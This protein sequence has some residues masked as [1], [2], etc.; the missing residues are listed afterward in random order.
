MKKIFFV[1]IF[2]LCANFSCKEQARDNA[3]VRHF[4]ENKALFERTAAYLNKKKETM[5]FLSERGVVFF[6]S[7]LLNNPRF[8][9][10]VKDTLKEAFSFKKFKSIN[11]YASGEIEFLLNT[12]KDDSV[13][14]L[15]ETKTIIL[16]SEGEKLPLSYLHWQKHL[17]I[18]RNWWYLEN[19]DAQY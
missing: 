9:S 16:F 11:Y 19:T 10:P 2:F 14:A 3:H 17:K 12:K 1:L 7:S 18:M 4:S 6:D 15:T 13:F 5:N 8:L